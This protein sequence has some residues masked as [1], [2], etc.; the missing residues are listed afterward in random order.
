MKETESDISK[1]ATNEIAAPKGTWKGLEYTEDL[2]PD[3]IAA[4]KGN[5]IGH[6]DTEDLTPEEIAERVL[7]DIQWEK[8]SRPVRRSRLFKEKLW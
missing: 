2:T 6:K 8:A 3:E 7:N 5:W 4:P 1:K